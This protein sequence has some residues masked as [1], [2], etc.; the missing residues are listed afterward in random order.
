MNVLVTGANGFIGSNLT[1]QLAKEGY[2][3][4]AMV[5]PGTPLHNLEGVDCKIVYADITKPETLKGLLKG[6]EVVYHLAALPSAAWTKNIF[7][8][9]YYGTQN[10]LNEAIHSNVRRFVFMSSLVVHGFRHF[11]QAD[12]S[13]PLMQPGTF[14]RPYIASKIRC[15]ELLASHKKDMEIVIVRPGFQIFGPNDMLTSRE[16]LQRI[17][18]KQFLAYV[19]SGTN[20]LGYVYV[21]NLVHG[22]VCAGS[23]PAAAGNTYVIADDEP[24]YIHTKDLFTLFAEKLG[25]DIKPASV[26]KAVLAPVAF[27]IDAFHFTALPNKMPIISTYIVK[28]ATHDIHFTPK[29]AM[30]EIGYRPKVKLHEGLE[31]TVAWYRTLK[32]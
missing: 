2:K 25:I 30:Q 27:L 15:E 14:T 26:P 21:D 6:I 13:T 11:H 7:N 3:V 23:H 32:K 18:Q 10:L 29:K 12:E 1:K 28:T 20:R 4:S 16:I 24:D 8:V 31:R 5:L 17:E 19:G 22:L 9:N